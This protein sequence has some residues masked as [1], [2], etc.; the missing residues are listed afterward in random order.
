MV[1]E[2]TV[3]VSD[4]LDKLVAEAGPKTNPVYTLP[5]ASVSLPPGKFNYVDI[6]QSPEVFCPTPAAAA[7]KA[8]INTRRAAR[9]HARVGGPG[10]L[11]SA[12]MKAL[13]KKQEKK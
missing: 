3:I 2:A 9:L 11:I 5:S 10:M 13:A 12:R 7:G 4:K 6:S 1:Y 8:Q